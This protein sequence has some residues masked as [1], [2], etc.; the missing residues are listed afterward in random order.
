MKNHWL[1]FPWCYC[2]SQGLGKGL[3]EINGDRYLVLTRQAAVLERTER[4]LNIVLVL[5]WAFSAMLALKKYKET[6]RI[7][8]MLPWQHSSVGGKHCAH[9]NKCSMSLKTQQVLSYQN[10]FTVGV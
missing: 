7:Q 6:V 8:W 9:S 5:K 4:V 10:N 1:S 3:I 2:S